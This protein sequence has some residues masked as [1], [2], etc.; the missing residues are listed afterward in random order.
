MLGLL[1]LIM[2]KFHL[3]LICSILGIIFSSLLLLVIKQL[4]HVLYNSWYRDSCA[5]LDKS[6]SGNCIPPNTEVIHKKTFTLFI[7]VLFILCAI[8]AHSILMLFA[9]LIFIS[10]LAILIV[11][12]YKTMLLPDELTIPLIWVGLLFNLNGLISGSL[13]NSIYGAV[14]GYLSLWSVFWVFKLLTKRDGLGY[15]DF[16][17]LSAI[18]AF[19]GFQYLVPMLLVSS[20]LG[21]LYF[22]L[23]TIW[24]KTQ[25]KQIDFK[26]DGAIPFGPYLSIAA[27]ILLFGGKNI[28]NILMI[29]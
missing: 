22:L 1:N 5:I 19:L 4:P 24:N 13:E 3:I 12:D 11:I 9:S 7:C 26:E 17:L 6:H 20:I 28:I 25:E 23:M 14:I 15:G 29:L 16:K 2:L 21:I 27:I 18:L 8:N 10:V